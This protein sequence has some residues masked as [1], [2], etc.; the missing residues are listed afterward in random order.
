ML[1]RKRTQPSGVCTAARRARTTSGTCHTARGAKSGNTYK[2]DFELYKQ[3][4]ISGVDNNKKWHRRLFKTWNDE[5]FAVRQPAE[6]DAGEDGE[7]VSVPSA[8]NAAT[9]MMNHLRLQNEDHSDSDNSSEDTSEPDIQ[10]PRN[11]PEDRTRTNAPLTVDTEWED[12]DNDD[13]P[14]KGLPVDKTP[15]EDSDSADETEDIQ[16]QAPVVPPVRE[17]SGPPASRPASA[18]VVFLSSRQPSLSRSSAGPPRSDVPESTQD[19]GII[20]TQPAGNSCPKPHPK[21]RSTSNIIAKAT[22]TI[23]EPVNEAGDNNDPK[24]VKGRKTR[25]KVSKP[26]KGKAKA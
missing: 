7:I 14:A 15:V 23:L 25:S 18:I 16:L 13:P 19:H 26:N 12:P 2:E 20:K 9:N 1:S 3:I 10:Q 6:R 11:V 4:I 17:A 5:L 24:E 21:G 8:L 22:N